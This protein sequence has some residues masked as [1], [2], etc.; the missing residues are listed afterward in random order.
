MTTKPTPKDV[1][2]RQAMRRISN[3]VSTELGVEVKPIDLS[4][5]GGREAMQYRMNALMSDLEA[6][7][8]HP[9]VLFAVDGAGHL[10]A[11]G[12]DPTEAAH[13]LRQM[14]DHMAAHP[15]V[16]R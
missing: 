11:M 1:L 12:V 9:P 6:Q 5:T 2:A 4:E 14:A 3:Q 7:G 15:G 10:M 16:E 13:L 8:P